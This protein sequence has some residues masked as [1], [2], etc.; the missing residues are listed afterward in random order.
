M[1][2][3]TFILAIILLDVMAL[4]FGSDSRDTLN[5]SEWNGRPRFWSLVTRNQY[6]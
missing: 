1:L 6:V 3:L 5:S 2:I 4:Y